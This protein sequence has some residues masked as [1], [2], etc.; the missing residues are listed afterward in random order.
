MKHRHF[1]GIRISQDN[2]AKHYNNG[3]AYIWVGKNKSQFE[4]SGSCYYFLL[5]GE[6]NTKVWCMVHGA[7]FGPLIPNQ[8]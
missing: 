7:V 8:T 4:E 3:Q 1:S 6:P 2:K 5:P